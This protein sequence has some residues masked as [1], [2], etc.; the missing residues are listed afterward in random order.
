MADP[1]NS[2][3]TRSAELYR[4]ACEVLPGGNTRT[5]VF[6]DP[7]PRYAVRG[8]GCTVVDADGTE[9]VDFLGNHTA[10]IHGYGEPAVTEAVVAQLADGSCFPMPTELEIELAEELRGRV[11]SLQ[12]LWFT[13][14]GS[15]AVMLAAKIARV[16]TGRPL[17]AKCEGAY[18]GTYE[19][20]Q[21]N[22]TAPPQPW[23]HGEG[24]TLPEHPG[25]APGLRDGTVVVPFNDA[26]TAA[27]ILRRHA[28]EL[29]AVVVDLMPNRAGLVPVL[30]EYL[31]ALR[32][33]TEDAGALLI[34]DEVITFRLGYGGAQQ[35]HAVRP[36]LTTLGKVIGGGLPI[37]AVGGRADVM[38]VLDPRTGPVLAH[39][40]TF[41]A[42]PL[43]MAA[44]LASL[45]LLTADA[46]D[47]LAG[48][49]DRLRSGVDSALA[50]A[51]VP[52]CVTGRGSLS[53]LHLTPGPVTDYGTSYPDDAA[54]TRLSRLCDHL[55]EHGVLIG[56]NGLVCL[57]TPMTEQH[58]D[59]LVDA[60]AAGLAEVTA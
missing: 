2:V 46:I 1:T 55:L 23:R 56:R 15:D 30:P 22:V 60:V 43:S 52:G 58:V 21:F 12:R 41:N 33:V 48:L 18:H 4:R 28:G 17:I 34:F 50:A 35:D 42:N 25:M 16:H 29:A 11:A 20:V 44:G 57:S 32:Q 53:R 59:R 40:G 36:D 38:S 45:R 6:V 8:H 31:A 54:R 49:G 39:G 47:R 51:G 9:L 24:R 7:H 5:T 14:S 26:E 37:G 19:S 27:A 3:T 10:L 13:G